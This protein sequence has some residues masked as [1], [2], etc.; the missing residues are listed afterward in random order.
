MN[1]RTRQLSWPRISNGRT[2]SVRLFMCT[3]TRNTSTLITSSSVE[4]SCASTNSVREHHGDGGHMSGLRAD[5]G[6]EVR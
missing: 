2:K 4:K 6:V 5:E 3:T 1:A